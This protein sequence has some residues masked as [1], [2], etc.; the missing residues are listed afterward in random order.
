MQI[1]DAATFGKIIRQYRKKQGLTQIQLSAMANTSPRL[2]GEL[3][4][5]K[6]TIQLEKALRIA[7]LLGIP[8]NVPDKD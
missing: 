1:K 7:W 4:N 5:G 8:F 6:P 2:I 3:E